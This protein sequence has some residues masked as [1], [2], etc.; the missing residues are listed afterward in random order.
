MTKTVYDEIKAEREYQLEKWGSDAD[1]L[2]NT[3][4]DFVGYIAMHSSRWFGGGFRP[5]P[6]EVLQV[7]RKQ[8]IKVATLA[9]A[10]IEHVDAILSGEVSRPD[11]LKA[12]HK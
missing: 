2:T 7:F 9:V 4:M 3:P 12:E 11:V 6:R 5:Y 8:M 1:L 10:A